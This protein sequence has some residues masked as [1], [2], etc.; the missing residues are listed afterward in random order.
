MGKVFQEKLAADVKIILT[1]LLSRDVNKYK[2]RNKILKVNSY[3]KKSCKDEINIYYLEP[4]RNW[5]HKDQSVD[6]SLY[7]RDHLHLIKPG[8]DKFVSKSVEILTK[9]DCK[10]SPL[11]PSSSS[12]SISSLSSQSSLPPSLTSPSALSPTSSLPPSLLSLLP[13]SA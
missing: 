8:N 2:R 13:P 4:D 12:K 11:T 6:T 7:F 9:L 10:N 3:L 1:C 5:V